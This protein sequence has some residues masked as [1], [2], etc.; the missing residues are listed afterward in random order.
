[1]ATPRVSSI[2]STEVLQHPQ[3]IRPL[4]VRFTT[5]VLRSYPTH[6]LHEAAR[7]PPHV[8]Q[9][10]DAKVLNALSSVFAHRNSI[11]VPIAD[12]FFETNREHCTGVIRHSRH[13]IPEFHTLIVGAAWADA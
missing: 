11:E 6:T 5:C 4:Q 8:H 2:T 10:V 1:M 7:D 13:A 9:N 3:R 12:K